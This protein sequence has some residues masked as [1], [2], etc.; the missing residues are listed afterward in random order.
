M[1][2]PSNTPMLGP[3]PPYHPKW[4]LDRFVHFCTTVP[5]SP[6]WLQWDA[7]YLPPKLSFPLTNLHPIW[8]TH[9]LT[10]PIHHPNWH[11][12]TISRF[13]TIHPLHSLTDR[14]TDSLGDKP[15][16][17]YLLTTLLHY[18]CL[19]AFFHE[20]WVRDDG[21]AVASAVPYANHLHLATDR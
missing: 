10:D 4:Q 16:Y 14:L 3:Q 15:V 7:P 8:Y 21:V 18:I 2:T 5:Q 19:M 6:L 12:G 11:P 17:Q 9:P 20:A 1:W 13:S